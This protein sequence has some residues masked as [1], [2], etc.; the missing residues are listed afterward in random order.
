[1]DSLGPHY[2]NWDMNLEKNTMWRETYRL[3]LRVDSFNIFNHPNLGVPN[4]Q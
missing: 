2:Q 1:M 3:Q 4:S